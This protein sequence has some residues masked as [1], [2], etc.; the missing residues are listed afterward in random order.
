MVAALGLDPCGAAARG[1]E[2]FALD[3]ARNGL[4][5]HAHQLGQG[6]GG[7][8][9]RIGAVEV[10]RFA[11]HGDGRFAAR[12]VAGAAQTEGDAPRAEVGIL[13]QESFFSRR[14]RRGGEA[15]DDEAEVHRLGGDDGARLVQA[16]RQG[17][18]G[19]AVRR[20]SIDPREFGEIGLRPAPAPA[21]RAGVR[22]G[23]QAQIQGLGVDGRHGTQRQG[24]LAGLR[25]GAG[26]EP[27]QGGH[28]RGGPEVTPGRREVLSR[29]RGVHG[30]RRPGLR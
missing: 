27:G 3:P 18:D 9:V 26:V 22:R 10:Q 24:R 5:I 29:E 12:R 7:V 1:G 30:M 23:M 2:A 16:P 25:A 6:A 19:A 21:T 14:P 20:G 13:A 11:A 17:V 4:A 15:R 8:V 28:F